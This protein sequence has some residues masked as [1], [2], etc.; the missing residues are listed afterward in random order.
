MAYSEFWTVYPNTD[1]K[2]CKGKRM[3]FIPSKQ[4]VPGKNNTSK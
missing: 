3:N 1:K 2:N 4:I